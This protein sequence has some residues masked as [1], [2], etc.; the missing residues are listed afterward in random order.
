[1]AIHTNRKF[2]SFDHLL[3]EVQVFS[4]TTS[5]H[6][7]STA[8]L[9]FHLACE[10]GFDT[11]TALALYDAA[12]VHDVGKIFIPSEII[13]KPGRLTEEERDIVRLHTTEGCKVLNFFAPDM[14]LAY[15]AS[16]YHH[17]R[18]DG[19]GY[20][21]GMMGN[22]IPEIARLLSITDVYDALRSKRSY[23]EPMTHEEAIYIMG[24]HKHMY[25]KD[26]YHSFMNLDVQLLN[27][28]ITNKYEKV[29]IVL[30]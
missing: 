2:R 7:T 16:L 24:E 8:I 13:N 9:T 4:L 5:E 1:M 12:K 22:D 29:D 3:E 28:I 11:T 27:N 10:Y 17:E 6:E 14:E 18:V 26:M 20:P 19:S 25:D 21:Y 15:Q 23:K 30:F